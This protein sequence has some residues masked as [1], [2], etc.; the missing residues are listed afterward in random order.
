M[1]GNCWRANKIT[2]IKAKAGQK[3]R[4]MD[5]NSNAKN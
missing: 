5:D 3:Q 4:N 2:I 1:K